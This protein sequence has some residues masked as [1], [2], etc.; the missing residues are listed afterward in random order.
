MLYYLLVSIIFRQI[1]CPVAY[2]CLTGTMMP[3]EGLRIKHYLL[4]QRIRTGGMGE[5]YLATD[6]QLN[7]RVAIKVIEIDYF[8]YNSSEEAEEAARLFV[9][10]AQAIAKFDHQYILP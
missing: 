4:L 9:R 3:R 2:L 1:L 7:R 5:V 6:E 10:E 8:G